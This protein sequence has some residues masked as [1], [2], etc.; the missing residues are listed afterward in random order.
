MRRLLFTVLVGVFLAAPA[1]ASGQAMV[2]AIPVRGT[3][4]QSLGTPRVA[5]FDDAGACAPSAYAITVA[6]GP[7]EASSPG[8][9]DRSANEGNGRCDYFAA[10]EHTYAQA[11]TYSFT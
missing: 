7:G 3:E 6:W 8:A 10:A 9:V 4:G 1:A 5:H 2:S 11:G